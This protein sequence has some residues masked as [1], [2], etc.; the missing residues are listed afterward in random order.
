[1]NDHSNMTPGKVVIAGGS[2]FI[3]RHL[4][5]ALAVAGHEVIVLGRASSSGR[6]PRSDGTTP[7]FVDWLPGTDGP[8]QQ[9]LAGAAAVI[10]LCGASIG[11]GRWTPARKQILI[12]SRTVPSQ[13]L[14]AA[15]IRLDDPPALLLQASGVG[16]YGTGEPARDE[17]SPA[18]DDY[19][20]QL[21]IAWEAPLRELA[22]HDG[23]P[24]G[25]CLRFGVVLGRDGGALPQMLLPFRLFAGGPIADGRQ[26]LSWIHIG[27]LIRAIEFIMAAKVDI[28]PGAAINVTA[29]HPLRN[30]DFARIAGRVLK[31]PALLRLPRFVLETAL[32]EQATLV[33]DG[34]RALPARLQAAGFA[35][36]F[37]TLEAALSDLMRPLGR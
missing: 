1:M 36:G 37:P 6:P 27:D 8:W 25:V 21:A 18:G 2:G 20:A 15:C 35:F 33:C 22:T 12:D 23:A 24:R 7:R 32:G 14:V 19:L 5:A 34:Q 26:W 29:P 31:R 28:G 30:A 11:N 4:A 17:D 3:G 16:Y 13:A 9:E 10:N